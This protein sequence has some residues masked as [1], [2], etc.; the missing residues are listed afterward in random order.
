MQVQHEPPT[1]TP[2]PP[3]P[4]T[5]TQMEELETV[6]YCESVLVGSFPSSETQTVRQL[7]RLSQEQQTGS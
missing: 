4:T 1:P 6:E 3:T 2:T 5:P 7:L